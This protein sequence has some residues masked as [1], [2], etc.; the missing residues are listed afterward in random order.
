MTLAKVSAKSISAK[1]AELYS[2]PSIYTKLEEAIKD[3]YCEL[4]DLAD[5]LLEDAGV[6]ARVLKLANSA[7]YNFPSKIDTITKAITIIGTRQLIDIVLATCV[8]N[9]F[10]NIDK[11]TVDMESFWRHSIA[12]GVCAKIIATYKRES[13]VE[14][15]YL[16]GLLH[17]IGRLVMYIQIPDHMRLILEQAQSNNDV[18]RRCEKAQL[19]FDF[20]EVGEYFLEEWKLPESIRK[21]VG[22]QYTLRTAV[23]Q[24]KIGAAIIHV[25][26]VMINALEMGSSGEVCVPALNPAAWEVLNLPSSQ[27]PT[28]IERLQQQYEDIVDVFLS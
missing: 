9:L 16:M 19:E 2:L 21:S 7:F 27:I 24:E 22:N 26:D 28:I 13:N 5:I 25:S 10:K 18:L 17:D 6:S 1:V 20:T 4:Q 3:P 12:V 15:F 8:I 11:K 23:E 14:R